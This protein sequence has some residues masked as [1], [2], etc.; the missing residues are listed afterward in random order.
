MLFINAILLHFIGLF[1]SHLK[2]IYLLHELAP[3][4]NVHKEQCWTRPQPGAQHSTRVGHVG[5]SITAPSKLVT[6]DPVIP[7]ATHSQTMHLPFPLH[8]LINNG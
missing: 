3:S 8:I 7:V 6:N 5:G 1:P 2:W 4:L